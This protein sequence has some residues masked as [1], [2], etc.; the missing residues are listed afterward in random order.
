MDKYYWIMKG[1]I[2]SCKALTSKVASG[3]S[4]EIHNSIMR[5]LLSLLLLSFAGA[6]AVVTSTAAAQSL[7]PTVRLQDSVSPE[8][9]G[10]GNTLG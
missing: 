5:K 9:F 8:Y 2:S 6:V 7:D 10:D 1:L 3:S 4:N